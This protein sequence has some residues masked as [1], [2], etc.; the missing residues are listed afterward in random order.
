M[1]QPDPSTVRYPG[2]WIHRDIHA[3]GI[4]FHTVEVGEH[5]PDAPLVILLQPQLL[6]LTCA[7]HLLDPCHD[8]AQRIHSEHIL[9]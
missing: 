5:A 8:A 4:R 9:A 6:N 2:Q 7:R 1:N 3:N